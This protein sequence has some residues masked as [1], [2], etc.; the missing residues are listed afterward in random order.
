MATKLHAHVE[1]D[2]RGAML[3]RREIMVFII[4]RTAYIGE[5]P[6]V[7]IVRE[8]GAI[9]PGEAGREAWDRIVSKMRVPLPASGPC[10]IEMCQP[11][12]YTITIYHEA[13]QAEQAVRFG[14]AA[15]RAA[16]KWLEG[17]I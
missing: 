16:A 17:A 12:N 3:D 14:I 15:M 1:K 9:H 4:D 11:D 13:G 7:E 8:G 10:R 5:R 2:A 6:Q